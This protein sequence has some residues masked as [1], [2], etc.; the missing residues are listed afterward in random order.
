M[1]AGSGPPRARRSREPVWTYGPE[2]IEALRK[3]WAV[4]DGPTGK[5][6]A[7]VMGELVASLR[8]HREL[9]ITDEVA[10]GLWIEAA[11]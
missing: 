4:L 6:L 8:R 11:E 9:D 5:R 1:T 10:V 2:V 3:V 7:P